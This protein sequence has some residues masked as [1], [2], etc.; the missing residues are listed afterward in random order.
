MKSKS[1]TNI[2]KNTRK[3]FQLISIKEPLLMGSNSMRFNF[4]GDYDLFNVVYVS[5]NKNQFI[6]K[7]IYAFKK[8]VKNVMK[9]KQLYYIEFMLGVDENNIPLKWNSKEILEGKKG[10]YL[11]KDIFN[12]KSV[13]KIEIIYYDGK[14]FIPISNVYEIRYKNGVGINRE[15]ETRD[16]KKSI[17]EDMMKY[18]SKGKRNYMKI[19]KRLFIISRL[20]KNKQLEQK[21][22]DIFNSDIGKIYKVKSDVEAIIKVMELYKNKTTRDR[23]KNSL[24]NLK[25]YLSNMN[26]YKNR[27]YTLFDGIPTINKLNKIKKHLL[28]ISNKLL[29]QKLKEDKININKYIK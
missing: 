22:I 21:L 10:N 19:L 23:I 9:D 12:N 29:L 3:V 7:I 24:Q 8:M 26:I 28:L 27:I 25:E 15:E 18:Y 1:I 14:N 5:K 20:D 4:S 6:N 11:L 16:D 13:F 2:D 17:I